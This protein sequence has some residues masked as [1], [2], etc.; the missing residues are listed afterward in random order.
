MK[1]TMEREL[2]IGQLLRMLLKK[3]QYIALITALVAVI[4]VAV[5]VLTTKPVYEAKAKMIINADTSRPIVSGDQLAASIKLVD[6]CTAII[7]S[8]TVLVPVIQTLNLPD[9]S[10]SLAS[11]ISVAP[12]NETQIMQITVRYENVETAKAI[13]AKIM[14]VAPAIIVEAL[15]A[16]PVKEVESVYAS[17]TPVSLSLTSTVVLYSVLGFALG[18]GL[19]IALHLLNN[20]FLTEYDIRQT[21][22]VP[23]LGVI[24]AVESCSKKRE[25]VRGELQ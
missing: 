8:R 10:D 14:E 18:C 4:G 3:A 22:G 17:D 12:V 7:R 23:V 2:D 13:T 25:K 9:S 20:T 6:T 16:S 24:P 11:K 19:F 1:D 5:S 15:E 21:L